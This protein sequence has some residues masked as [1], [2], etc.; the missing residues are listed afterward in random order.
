LNTR[1]GALEQAILTN[2]AKAIELPLL[3]RDLDTIKRDQSDQIT[4][5]QNQLNQFVD[6][7]KWFI[8][9]VFGAIVSLAIG[10]L[11]QQ[12]GKQAASNDNE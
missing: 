5:L 6:L 11:L 3:Q 12:R 1:L 9:L 2:P 7:G 4:T 10:N 8:G